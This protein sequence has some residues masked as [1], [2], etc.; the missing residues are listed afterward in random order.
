ME[1]N[2]SDTRA[3]ADK[4]KNSLFL[5]KEIFDHAIIYTT[6]KIEENA[7]LIYLK[8]LYE[9][10]KKS[11]EKREDGGNI[12]HDDQ[13]YVTLDNW[14]SYNESI[15]GQD[16]ICSANLT[17]NVCKSLWILL[18][19]T[20]Q[21]VKKKNNVNGQK[22]IFNAT[23][24]ELNKQ[25][26]DRREGERHR[27]DVQSMWRD[28][29][30]GIISFNSNHT[31]G[32][33]QFGKTA[34]HMESSSVGDVEPH[35]HCGERRDTAHDAWN[36][37]WL[38]EEVCIE[39][40]IF[41]IILQFLKI[42][43][44]KRKYDKNLSEDSWPH[45]G[46]SPRSLSNSS[47]GLGSGN[48]IGSSGVNGS[49]SSSNCVSKSNLS[50][51][52]HF[53]GKNY[54]HFLK[55]YLI[56]F[57]CSTDIVN[58]S[59]LTDTPLY[60]KSQHLFLLDFIIDTNDHTNVY[61]KYLQKNQPK[62]LYKTKE[63]LTWLLTNL[64]MAD[65][66]GDDMVK[67]ASPKGQSLSPNPHP[68]CGS[69]DTN[70]PHY[71]IENINNDIYEIN[72]VHGKTI[73]ITSDKNI[74]NIS[75]CK[76]CNI[77]IF[78]NVEYLK[79]HL[80]VNC[81]IISLAIEMISTFFN[82]KNLDVHLVTRSLKIENVIDTNVYVY[83]ETNIIIFGD[84]RNIQLAPY[85]ILNSNQSRCLRKS[86][87][88]FG[89]KNCD[90]F[91][92]PLKCKTSLFHSTNLSGGGNLSLSLKCSSGALCRRSDISG[93]RATSSGASDISA[94]DMGATANGSIAGDATIANDVISAEEK[95][96]GACGKSFDMT[97]LSSS[98]TDYVYY[99]LSPSKFF[100]TE[101][102]SPNCSS[103]GGDRSSSGGG[104]HEEGCASH[105]D[106]YHG[107]SHKKEIAP[108]KGTYNTGENQ[109]YECLYLPEVYKNAIEN[110]DDHILQFLSFMESIHLSG[111]QMQK[112]KKI[113]T[114]KLYAYLKT[115]K[116]AFRVLN[117]FVSQEQ[118]TPSGR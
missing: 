65:S 64:C 101:F 91:A 32:S 28:D 7:L 30:N 103:K 110:Q 25:G 59:T 104:K 72:N 107:D 41:F 66:V 71:G 4:G 42:D 93:K 75:N 6:N 52:F 14:L 113:L 96:E 92:F 37:N 44:V 22:T 50:D 68:P 54:N 111:T 67:G 105:L 97:N 40:V 19:I 16:N 60:F 53:C 114:Y 48:G 57:L 112:V 98:F 78:S 118:E 27:E 21:S 36:E 2:N 84:T 18:S 9:H 95:N 70:G 15:K 49:S 12:H 115:S 58:S 116:K 100:L 99:L 29:T 83:T 89:R 47:S 87:I 56:A 3:R 77:F 108:E 102:P 17:H 88:S 39:L 34:I 46:S 81:C 117:D 79:I 62:I 74:V 55:T 24:E 5:R 10:F 26:G 45:F 61:E 35:S 73:Y 31:N 8:N 63:I 109:K 1:R 94:I 106:D 51:F 23:L 86:K 80:C 90:L 20:L 76:E 69:N 43:N 82:S 85:N 11:K 38:D 13:M 33:S